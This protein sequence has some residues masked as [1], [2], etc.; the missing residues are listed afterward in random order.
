MTAE[1]FV[2]KP[3]QGERLAFMGQV[4]FV[5]AT[6]DHTGGALTLTETRTPAGNGPP[7]HVHENEDEMFYVIEGELSFTL[8][9]ETHVAPAGSFVFAPRGVPHAYKATTPTRHLG[10][11][12]PPG[13]ERFLHDAGEAAIAG[14]QALA[15]VAARYGI[16]MLESRGGDG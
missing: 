12:T 7:K 16:T 13:F 8:G 14:P 3:G 4:S 10:I 15:S 5:R 11:I 6:G 2:S 9:E 1:P